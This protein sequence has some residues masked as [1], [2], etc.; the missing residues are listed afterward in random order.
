M[1]SSFAIIHPGN[2]TTE[3]L[4][5]DGAVI[6]A[7][8]RPRART[9]EF[10]VGRPSGGRQKRPPRLIP[11][12]FSGAIAATLSTTRVCDAIIWPAV[13]AITDESFCAALG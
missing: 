6:D 8:K 12:H 5:H 2:V 3:M 7:R 11:P 9:W 13:A 10:A 4:S 1:I